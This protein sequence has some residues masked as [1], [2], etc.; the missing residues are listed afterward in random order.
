MNE[1]FHYSVLQ[2]RKL[3]SATEIDP[4][5]IK[6]NSNEYLNYSIFNSFYL[7]RKLIDKA[8]ILEIKA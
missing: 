4:T 2:E 3:E 1:I 5:A 7:H 6:I 8:E